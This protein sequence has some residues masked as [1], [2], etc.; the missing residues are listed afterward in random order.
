MTVPVAEAEI[1]GGVPSFHDHLVQV[2]LADISGLTHVEFE[3]EWTLSDTAIPGSSPTKKGEFQLRATAF[4]ANPGGAPYALF[5]VQDSESV[6]YLASAG[7]TATSNTLRVTLPLSADTD[8][9]TFTNTATFLVDDEFESQRTAIGYAMVASDSTAI[10][11][12][13]LRCATSMLPGVSVASFP[14]STGGS[15]SAAMFTV[16]STCGVGGPDSSSESSSSLDCAPAMNTGPRQSNGYQCH[17][18]WAEAL[19]WG[20]CGDPPVDCYAYGIHGFTL[21]TILGA[22]VSL[23][24][25]GEGYP[26]FERCRFDGLIRNNCGT[27]DSVYGWPVRGCVSATLVSTFHVGGLP[28]VTAR[29]CIDP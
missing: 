2:T 23:F 8:F 17:E 25:N 24:G 27:S 5:D 10:P 28:P 16:G 18:T 29:D 9:F 7:Q 14:V 13:G 26:L 11:S 1:L 6:S 22:E 20:E 12:P 19:G 21:S 15:R 4:A 3:F